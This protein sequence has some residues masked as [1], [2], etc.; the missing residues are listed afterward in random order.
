ME[1]SLKIWMIILSFV[2][3]RIVQKSE[4]LRLYLQIK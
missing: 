3:L 1:I 2:N 4:Q